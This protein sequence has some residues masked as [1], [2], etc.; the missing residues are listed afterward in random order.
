MLNVYA[1]RVAMENKMDKPGC[2]GLSI[3]MFSVE[4]TGIFL[5]TGLSIT[6]T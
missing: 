3:Y 1:V 4:L 5:L 6:D 2:F